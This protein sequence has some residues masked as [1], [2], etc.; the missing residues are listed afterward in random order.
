MLW[1]T[2]ECQVVKNTQQVVRQ[3]VMKLSNALTAFDLTGM[4]MT[5]S[6]SNS[7]IGPSL[8]ALVLV[9]LDHFVK[10]CVFRFAYQPHHVLRIAEYTHDFHETGKGNLAR[11]LKPLYGGQRHAARLRQR[12]L[13]HV[14]LQSAQPAVSR[15]PFEDVFR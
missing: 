14:L 13:R 12:L 5:F 11:M 15:Q 3:N 2:A 10:T 7:F 6:E 8:S 4:H 9:D 1:I